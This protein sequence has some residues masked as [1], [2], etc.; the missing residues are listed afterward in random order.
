[1]VRHADEAGVWHAPAMAV[2]WLASVLVIAAVSLGIRILCERL[3]LDKRLPP[4]RP[5]G[6]TDQVVGVLFVVAV[7]VLWTASS[8]AVQV[9]FEDAHYRKPFF[10]TYFS[11]ALLIV[12]L[13]FYPA[14]L[15]QVAA[16]CV[17]NLGCCTAA[18]ARAAGPM[19][20]ASIATAA[21]NGGGG[22]LRE[23]TLEFDG[24]AVGTGMGVQPTLLLAAQLGCLFF[25]F[26]YCFNIGLELTTVSASSVLSSSS[27]LWTLIFSAC[28]LG[29]RV[30]LVKLVAVLFTFLGVCLVVLSG[31]RF[32]AL[33]AQSASSPL[34]GNVITL[35][36]AMLYG[37][38]AT[39]L[40]RMVPSEQALPMPFLFGLIGLL[41]CCLFLPFFAILQYVRLEAFV[42]PTRSAL[43]VMT[44]NALLGTVMA[45][46]LLARAMLLASPL[47]AT[48]GLSLSIPFAMLSDLIRGRAH[49]SIAMALGSCAVWAG[50]I[51]VAAASTIEPQAEA[52]LKRAGCCR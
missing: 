44:L 12:Y 29:E 47:V 30:S 27:G 50:F 19:R 33:S 43:V 51:L 22:Q 32:K 9:V 23:Y 8:V 41:N 21:E 20:Y 5:K 38:Y 2:L 14:Q 35:F 28:V 6:R 26:N 1:M 15:A 52:M 49:F 7:V 31:E 11:S 25:V 45:N 10:L 34:G 18:R 13:P 40:K 42:L 16:Y 4:C 3:R 46:M 24:A 36:S 17:A 39:Q 48:V 37:G